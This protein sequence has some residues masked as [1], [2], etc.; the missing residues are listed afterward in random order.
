MYAHDQCRNTETYNNVG[1]NI[2]MY[3]TKSVKAINYTVVLE[4]VLK[5]WLRQAESVNMKLVE[6]FRS[7]SGF[8]T[9]DFL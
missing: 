1:Q 5:S 7:D 4:G 6:K 2:A 8:E 9:F 3:S